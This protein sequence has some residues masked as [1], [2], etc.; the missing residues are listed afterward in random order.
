[1]KKKS[2][3]SVSANFRISME[4]Y[5]FDLMVSIN[6]DD[7][8]L[9]AVLDSIG[10]LTED[11]ISACGYPSP[12]VKG[13]AV[14]FSTNASIIRL[15]VLPRTSEDYSVLAHEIFHI[16][17]FVLN[18]VGIPL[19]LGKSDEAYAYLIGYLTKKIYDGMNKYY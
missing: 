9:G 8:Q 6:Q 16:A 1:M 7:D 5:P 15:R 2:A 18:R 13:R 17:S 11:D 3:K 4:V 12:F 19:K 14:M 10:N